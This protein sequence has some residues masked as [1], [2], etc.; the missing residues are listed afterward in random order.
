MFNC[1]KLVLSCQSDVFCTMFNVGKWKKL[2]T[3]NGEVKID[4]VKP[5][6]METLIYFIYHDA[7]Q[8][9]IFKFPKWSKVFLIN[10]Y[11]TWFHEIRVLPN[12]WTNFEPIRKKHTRVGLN[13][14]I[15]SRRLILIFQKNVK[16]QASWNRVVNSLNIRQIS[17]SPDPTTNSETMYPNLMLSKL[18]ILL[19][20]DFLLEFLINTTYI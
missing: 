12:F 5:E 9:R 20:S 18:M 10:L 3:K 2:E 14:S 17:Y 16:I 13:F 19:N 7:I 4:D 1:H 6:V 11:I 8:A 15:R